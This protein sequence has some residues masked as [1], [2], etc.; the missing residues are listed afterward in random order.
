[1]SERIISGLVILMGLI[2]G[3]VGVAMARHQLHA[4]GRVHRKTELLYAAMP[5]GWGSWFLGGFSI[6]PAGSRW[7]W[8]AAALASW[9]LIGLLLIGLGIRLGWS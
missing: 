3:G 6:L 2:A 1:M 8:A 4:A 9:T 7:L 5:E